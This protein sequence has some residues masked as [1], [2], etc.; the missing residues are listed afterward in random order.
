MNTRIW[1]AGLAAAFLALSAV[2]FE[3]NA[4]DSLQ[5]VA[6]RQ[7]ASASVYLNLCPD[8]RPGA[9]LDALAKEHGIV[10]ADLAE[11]GRFHQVAVSHA[12]QFKGA[13]SISG[14]AAD[15]TACRRA[16]EQYGPKGYAARDVLAPR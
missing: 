3:A 10:P 7:I 15:G 5:L 9:G 1:K 14:A 6:V 4:A 2:K 11:G 16:I 12:A 13:L 8:L